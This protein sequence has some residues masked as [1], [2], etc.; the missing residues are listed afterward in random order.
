M[1]IT[2]QAPEPRGSACKGKGAADANNIRVKRR[3]RPNVGTVQGA[4]HGGRLRGAMPG[5][6]P[7]RLAAGIERHGR[8]RTATE[9]KRPTGPPAHGRRRNA[10]V[11]AGVEKAGA[12]DPRY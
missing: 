5:A 11:Y 12:H 6:I 2:P 7:A 1:I 9:K 3:R 4:G 8:R 10:P